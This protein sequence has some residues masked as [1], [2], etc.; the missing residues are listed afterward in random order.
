M[1]SSHFWRSRGLSNQDYSHITFLRY[2]YISYRSGLKGCGCIVLL[3]MG[4]DGLLLAC[5]WAY[6]KHKPVYLLTNSVSTI[7]EKNSCKL[8]LYGMVW[9]LSSI[10]CSSSV[11]CSDCLSCFVRTTHKAD[12]LSWIIC[13]QS[14]CGTYSRFPWCY[15]RQVTLYKNYTLNHL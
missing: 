6:A 14:K 5:L 11:H 4:F 3:L 10:Q 1:V 13:S 15:R 12:G 9:V 2:F 8:I 7:G